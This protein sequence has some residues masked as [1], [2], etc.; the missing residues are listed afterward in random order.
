MFTFYLR[1]KKANITPLAGADLKEM[2]TNAKESACGTDQW[3][4][5]D[6]KL[7]SN[8]AYEHLAELLNSI[9]VNGGWPQEITHVRAA[10]LSKEEEEA[11]DPPGF[12]CLLMLPAVY[13]L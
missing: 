5:G 8:L 13:R 3:A 4:P 12:R 6:F 7:L 1:R 9:E 11:L 10:F 2:A